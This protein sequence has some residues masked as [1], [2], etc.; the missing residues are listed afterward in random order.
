M[1]GLADLL[2]LGQPDPA[3]QI[4]LALSGQQP[5]PPQPAQGGAAPQGGPPPNAAGAA[6]NPSPGQP[7]PPGTPPQPQATQST[8]DMAA[9]Y[10]QLANPPNLMQ[11]Y[12]QLDARNRAEA[13]INRGL[14]LIAANYAGNP[15]SARMIMEAA[16]AGQQDAGSTVQNLMSLYGQQQAMAGQQALLAQSPEI[17]QRLGMSEAVIRAQILAGHG[18]ELVRSMEPTEQARNIQLQHDMYIKNGGTEDD[19]RTNILPNVMMASLPGMNNPDMMSYTKEVRAWQAA[20]PGQPLPDNLKD[21]TRWHDSVLQESAARKDKTDQVLAAQ[22]GMKG[23]LGS[24]NTMD[25]QISDLQDAYDKGKLDRILA[26]PNG[27]IK[28]LAEGGRGGIDSFLKA[29]L[30]GSSALG[31][32]WSDDDVNY[33]KKINELTKTDMQSLGATSARNIAPQ[34]TTIGSKLGPLLSFAGKDQFGKN[35]DDLREAVLNGQAGVYGS[36]NV[37]PDSQDLRIRIGKS[38]LYA[39]GGDLNLRTATPLPEAQI[40]QAVAA[41]KDN[42]SMRGDII[43]G[44]KGGNYDTKELERRLNHG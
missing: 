15:Q 14:G 2:Y 23:L 28:S 7:P 25:S 27:G 10:Q 40:A 8:P 6:P 26:L 5:Q 20:N 1:P 36:A 29:Y 42:P 39:A 11:L 35:L 38:P 13:G 17:A 43:A 4:A 31:A 21:F 9:S 32:T 41:I 3:R 44:L 19:W 33:A 16:G 22:S 18:D 24:L 37:T 30:P 34:F 12:L